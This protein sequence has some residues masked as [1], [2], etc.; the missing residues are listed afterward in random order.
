MINFFFRAFLSDG[1]HNAFVIA[2]TSQDTLLYKTLAEG[3]SITLIFDIELV[4]EGLVVD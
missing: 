3:I 1:K 4:K 2:H